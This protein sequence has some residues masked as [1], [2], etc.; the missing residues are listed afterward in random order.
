M[1]GALHNNNNA[2]PESWRLLSKEPGARK[3]RYVDPDFQEL[4]YQNLWS[5]V[6]Q[7]AARLDK[8]PAEGGFTTYEIGNQSV[9][10]VRVDNDSVKAYHNICPHRVPLYRREIVGILSAKK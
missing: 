8:I 6:W 10:V 1:S 9:I 3:G 4:E 5:K 2:W 7:C